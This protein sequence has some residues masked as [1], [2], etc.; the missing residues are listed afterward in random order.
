MPLLLN[1]N[2]PIPTFSPCIHATHFPQMSVLGSLYLSL[3]TPFLNEIIS[4]DGFTYH[5]H[6]DDTQLIMSFPPSDTHVSA[7]ISARLADYRVPST[8]FLWQPESDLKHAWLPRLA[9]ISLKAVIKLCSALHF[10]QASSTAQPSIPEDTRKACI[11]ALFWRLTSPGCP[12]SWV[13][14]FLSTQTQD[15][16]F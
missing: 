3:C 4:S 6:A 13:F 2:L 9:P 10:L 1:S 8:D 14:G 16:V 12:S 11:K 7:R 5:C 15:V